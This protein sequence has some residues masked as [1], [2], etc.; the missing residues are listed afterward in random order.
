M[1][2]LTMRSLLIILLVIASIAGYRLTLGAS[3][4]PSAVLKLKSLEIVDDSGATR[5][6]LQVSKDNTAS[7]ILCGATGKT[8]EL[9]LSVDATGSST[10]K[11]G[12]KEAAL[13]VCADSHDNQIRLDNS[14]DNGPI[15][16]LNNE[17]DG[18]MI[19]LSARSNRT[20][21]DINQGPD[22]MVGVS[23]FAGTPNLYVLNG[24]SIDDCGITADVN[25]N[26]VS[27]FQVKRGPQQS[28]AM[29]IDREPF[30][31]VSNNGL[32][33]SYSASDE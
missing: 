28:V 8:D 21:I 26:G 33:K 16:S 6:K 30:F 2:K 20:A 18:T 14:N 9:T 24:H 3:E 22:K 23:I 13:L 4:V 25:D 27:S 10:V 7:I 29:Q 19:L 17:E 1:L 32:F 11:L 15:M 31:A 12:G 5:I